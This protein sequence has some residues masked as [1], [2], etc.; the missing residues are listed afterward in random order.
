MITVYTVILGGY[1]HLW[2][3]AVI[4]PGVRYICYSD[5]PLRC[6]PWEIQPAFQPYPEAHRNSRIP[7]ILAHLHA[8]TEYSIYHD[9]CLTMSAKPSDLIKAHLQ[10]AQIAMYRHPCR[11][12]V[13]EELECCA[14]LGIGHDR[15]M[16]RQVE[17][18]RAHGLAEGLWAGGVIIRKHTD[19]VALLNEVWWR[20][21]IGGCTR[22]QI[23]FPFA[24]LGVGLKVHTI[25]ADILT[26]SGR[27]QFHFHAGFKAAADPGLVEAREKRGRRM[28]RLKA[29]C[30]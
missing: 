3:P 14:R 12:S 30:V 9:G 15:M 27:F 29:L 19:I 17:R 22:D 26:D 4:E 23:A 11:K 25:D 10:D 7:K 2:P 8:D 18:Y 21:Y 5:E 16:E 20:E 24:R 1:D 13:E 6:A 28:A